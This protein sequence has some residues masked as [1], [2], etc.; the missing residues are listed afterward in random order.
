M[1]DVHVLWD[2]SVPPA[3]YAG[4]L[5]KTPASATVAVV[6]PAGTSLACMALRRRHAFVRFVARACTAPTHLV[7]PSPA[8]NLPIDTSS[9]RTLAHVSCLGVVGQPHW[10]FLDDD[11][12]VAKANPVVTVVVPTTVSTPPDDVARLVALTRRQTWTANEVIVVDHSP[13]SRTAIQDVC[14]EHGDGAVRYVR[15]V[16]GAGCA[17]ASLNIGGGLAL[18][19]V[20]KPMLPHDWWLTDD[21]LGAVAR[22]MAKQPGRAWGVL[23]TVVSPSSVVL[24][25]GAALQAPFSQTR[26]GFAGADLETRLHAQF[27]DPALVHSDVQLVSTLNVVSSAKQSTVG[28]TAQKRRHCRR[29]R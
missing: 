15:N 10:S 29:K 24:R 26:L 12:S 18:G 23:G 17:G 16:F 13:P 6:D 9:F 27:G 11:G 7:V 5:S 3:F 21:A 4:A 25:Q 14:D 1:F 28:G 22:A 19:D 20:V 2:P 8:V